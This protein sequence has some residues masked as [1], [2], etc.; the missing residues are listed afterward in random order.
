ME[1]TEMLI[2][3]TSEVLQKKFNNSEKSRIKIHKDRL[4][5]ACPICGDSH[6]DNSKKRG[7]IYLGS[8]IYKCYNCGYFSSLKD[9]FNKLKGFGLAENVPFEI[10]KLQTT[11]KSVNGNYGGNAKLSK[12]YTNLS[13]IL[14]NYGFDVEDLKLALGF[15]DIKGTFGERY[16][17]SRLVPESLFHY[18]LYDK[19][20]NRIVILNK[21][22]ETCRII[23]L[24]F[25]N[26]NTKY[27]KYITYKLSKLY[28]YLKMDI[29]TS[30]DFENLDD[31]SI[32]FNFLN[33][34]LSNN[35]TVFEGFI[36]SLFVQ[37]SFT[38]S[39]ARNQSPLEADNVRYLLDYDETGRDAMRKL[40]KSKRTVFMWEKMIKDCGINWDKNK[41]LDFN[42]LMMILKEKDKSINV[43]KYFTNNILDFI[44]V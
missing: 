40:L 38:L 20:F 5:I 30:E 16:L 33:C 39:S 14:E 11:F 9:F 13:E 21:E 34:N 41:K 29:P 3:L 2:E 32:F 28:T 43:N 6:Q 10:S 25:R 23:A 27:E 15:E 12:I 22:N 31:I 18:F 26:F 42:A 24:Q 8:N 37:N 36:D 19:K 35:I 1:T 7:N 4:N 44:Y 17:K